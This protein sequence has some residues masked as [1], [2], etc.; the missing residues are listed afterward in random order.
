MQSN[1]N[2]PKKPL[3]GAAKARDRVARGLPRYTPTELAS[4]Q[5]YDKE[6]AQQLAEIKTAFV[7]ELKLTR[8]C[9][10]CGYNAHS[11]ALHFDHLPGFEKR[12]AIAQMTHTRASMAKLLAEI[13]KCEVVCANCH[14]VRTADR[15][16]EA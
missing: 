13:N 11:A 3:S 1:I 2:I 10:D 5:K 9:A 6:R 14:A 12:S 7:T 4:R 16:R 15:R 8:G